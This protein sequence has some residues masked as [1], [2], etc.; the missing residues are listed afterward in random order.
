VQLLLNNGLQIH[1]DTIPFAD[2]TSMQI[3]A[4]LSRGSH[5]PRQPEPPLS[6]GAWE[7]IQSCWVRE[8][9]KRPGIEEVTDIMISRF[10]ARQLA[11]QHPLPYP[12]SFISYTMV[13]LMP[14]S[15]VSAQTSATVSGPESGV[16]LHMV[17]DSQLPEKKHACTMCHKR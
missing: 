15:Q 4:L 6:D 10:M 2:K 14:S 17:P 5:P 16:G 11:A 9:S 13:E 12:I 7:L 3:L 8:A 1:Y